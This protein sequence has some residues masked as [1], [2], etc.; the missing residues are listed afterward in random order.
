MNKPGF[1]SVVIVLAA[2]LVFSVPAV[3]TAAT[4]VLKGARVH[5]AA[6]PAIENAV[7]LIENGRIAAVGRDVAVPAGAE[8]LD[9]TGMTIIPGLIDAYSH[10]GMTASGLAADL[11]RAAGPE[12][13]AIDGLHLNVPDWMDAVRAGVTTVVTGPGFDSLVG[14]QTVTLKTFGSDFEKRVLKEAGE[15][16]LAVSG[17][18]LSQI[19]ALRA[20]LIAAREYLERREKVAAQGKNSA[21][22]R[23]L[24]LESLAAALNGRETI[25]ARVLWA[26]DILSLLELKDEFD[27]ALQLIDAPEAWKVAGEIASRNV[28]VVCPPM[29]LHTSYPEEVFRGAA[30]LQRAGVRTARRSDFPFAPQKHF[31]LNAA[32]SVRYGLAADEALKAVTLDPA[33]L[34]RIDG[35]VGSLEPGKDADLVVL[36]GSWFEPSSRV[37]MVFVDGALAFRRADDP[38]AP[39]GKGGLK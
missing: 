7:L 34:A 3:S 13:R 36:N 37:E 15:V 18:S 14:G 20:R 5:T 17:A 28:G 39:A 30:A 11:P 32:M 19:A 6:G 10:L 9:V 35:R 26:H 25:R 22:D 2:A 31:R 23:D 4:I 27:L 16:L 38:S 24:G 1:P 12:Q 21:P 8:V 33:R 29:V